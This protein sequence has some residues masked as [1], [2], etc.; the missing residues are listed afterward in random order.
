M[1]ELV[2]ISA[3]RRTLAV[4]ASGSGEVVE[5]PPEQAVA[6]EELEMEAGRKLKHA[7]RKKRVNTSHFQKSVTKLI[8][9]LVVPV[10]KLQE[11][12]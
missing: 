11:H 8:D 4:V 6:T 3:P 1:C 9:G 5:A 12:G 7:R 10:G 2:R